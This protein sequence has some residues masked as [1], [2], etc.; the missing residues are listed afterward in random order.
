MDFHQRSGDGNSK[1]ISMMSKYFRFPEG[2]DNFLYLSQVQQALA[3]KTG[4]EYWRHL[5]PVCVWAAALSWV[6]AVRP[7]AGRLINE[8]EPLRCW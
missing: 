3:I 7:D 6:S 8:G 2:M 4:V 5:R 1:I